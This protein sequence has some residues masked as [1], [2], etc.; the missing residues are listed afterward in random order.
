MRTTPGRVSEG[1]CWDQRG[2]STPSARSVVSVVPG[3]GRGD[4]VRRSSTDVE[5]AYWA[6]PSPED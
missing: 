6:K 1:I 4:T 3:A 5:G 2:V